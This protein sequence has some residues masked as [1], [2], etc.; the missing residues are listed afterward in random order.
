LGVAYLDL[1]A[2]HAHEHGWNR[3][4]WGVAIYPFIE[5]QPLYDAYDPKLRGTAY[6]N[7]CNTANS[8][9]PGAPAAQAIS[10]LF[11]PS[12]GMGGQARQFRHCPGK[13]CV[14]NY[15]AFLG[16]RPYECSLPVWHER[17]QLHCAPGLQ[18]KKAAFGIGASR[19]VPLVALTNLA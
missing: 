4:A 17:F 6:T 10:T 16:D 2:G 9:G 18:T 7:W 8:N 5:Q 13:F 12:D 3:Q 19:Q 15:M 1:T 14:S 11:C